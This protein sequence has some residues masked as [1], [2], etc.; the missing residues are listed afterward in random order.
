M[1]GCRSCPSILAE[2]ISH[3]PYGV[4]PDSVPVAERHHAELNGSA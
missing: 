3:V 2:W 1:V 4:A